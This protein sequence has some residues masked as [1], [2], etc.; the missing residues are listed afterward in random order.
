MGVE[1]G[2]LK[3]TE[4]TKPVTTEIISVD[5]KILTLSEYFDMSGSCYKNNV[6]IVQKIIPTQN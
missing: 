4:E 3:S 5:K 1:F 6:K 2:N